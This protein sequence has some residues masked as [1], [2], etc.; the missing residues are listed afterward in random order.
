MS[1][2][3]EPRAGTVSIY[4]YN[5]CI[6]VRD[7]SYLNR[8]QPL[9]TYVHVDCGLHPDDKFAGRQYSGQTKP[10]RETDYV[11][12]YLLAY[13]TDGKKTGRRM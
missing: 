2:V 11:D 9:R 1:L 6:P 4:I 10:A 13:Y 3:V 7:R 5:T 8:Y 12:I